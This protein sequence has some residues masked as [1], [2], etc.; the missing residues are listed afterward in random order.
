MAVNRLFGLNTSKC[1][2]KSRA[3]YEAPGKNDSNDFFLGMLV[4]EIMF[5]ANGD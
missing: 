1:F 3:S 5:D 4:L 2:S